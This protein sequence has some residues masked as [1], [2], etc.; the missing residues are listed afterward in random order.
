MDG[1]GFALESYDVTGEWRAKYRAVGGG[2]GPE[3]D[4]IVNGHHIQY[5][6]GLPVDCAGTMPDGRAFADADQLRELLASEPDRLARAFVGNLVTYAT[7]EAVSFADRAVVDA[8][9]AKAKAKG[10]GIRTLIHE[11][12][13]S[14]LFRTK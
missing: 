2:K 12:I 5:H 6:Y 14:D 10:Y 11:T 7:G 8:I 4:T 1:Y 3:K 9:V 13:Q